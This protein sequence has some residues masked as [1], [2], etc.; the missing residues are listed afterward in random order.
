MGLAPSLLS[1]LPTP[2]VAGLFQ[3]GKRR[4]DSPFLFSRLQMQLK[5]EKSRER[6]RGERRVRRRKAGREGRKEEGGSKG[7]REGEGGKERKRG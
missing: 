1:R 2:D 3:T 6:K 4:E 7:A 5:K